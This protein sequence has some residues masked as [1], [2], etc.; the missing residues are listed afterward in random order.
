MSRSPFHLP[1][2]NNLPY[3]QVGKHIGHH[4]GRVA[5]RIDG[6]VYSIGECCEL[7]GLDSKAFRRRYSKVKNNRRNEEVTWDRIKA[8]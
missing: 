1:I 8:K 7:S 2:N 3:K 6:K 4:E 5:F